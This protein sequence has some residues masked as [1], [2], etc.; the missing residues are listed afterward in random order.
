MRRAVLGRVGSQCGAGIVHR[1][2]SAGRSPN[3]ACV[4]PRIPAPA[5]SLE[6]R[7]IGSPRLCRARAA[8]A[9]NCRR[10]AKVGL[11]I[12]A[13]WPRRL[14]TATMSLPNTSPQ[15]PRPCC[16]SR[17]VRRVRGGRRPVGRTAWRL[18]SPT[19]CAQ[20]TSS[21]TSSGQRQSL[22]SSAF[23]RPAWWAPARRKDVQRGRLTDPMDGETPAYTAHSSTGS[24]GAQ[25]EP[26]QRPPGLGIALVSMEI[27]PSGNPERA[28]DANL[29]PALD[30]RAWTVPDYPVARDLKPW[31]QR[32]TPDA[33]DSCPY[34]ATAGPAE[35]R[36]Q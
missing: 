35:M 14:I 4:S 18:R 36:R 23:D 11:E 32:L 33:A 19:R 10:P 25:A 29:F 20:P 30:R 5:G 12:S 34:G 28:H 1:S 3:P 9:G 8:W 21:T 27:S 7:N 6:C 2:F 22:I 24:T 16:W 26:R 17:S 15:Q 31:R 13:W